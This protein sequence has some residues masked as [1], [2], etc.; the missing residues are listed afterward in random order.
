VPA[1]WPLEHIRCQSVPQRLSHPIRRVPAEGRHDVAV[2]VGRGA[3]LRVAEDR[4]R[5]HDFDA[6]LGGGVPVEVLFERVAGLDIGQQTSVR[7]R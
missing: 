5:I 6:A 3:H 7:R 4:S 1:W 2:G